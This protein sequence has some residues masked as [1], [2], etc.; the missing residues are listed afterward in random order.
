[1]VL[2]GLEDPQMSESGATFP[3]QVLSLEDNYRVQVK[4][5]QHLLGQIQQ[6][7]LPDSERQAAQKLATDLGLTLGGVG[8]TEASQLAWTIAQRLT[9]TTSFTA[10]TLND[11]NV[12]G[13]KLAELT[14]ADA[15]AS[16]IDPERPLE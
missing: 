8:F 15:N 12:W 3:Q 5:L 9:E 16:E 1:M 14:Q 11:L 6:E 4:Q 13:A 7:V 10:D 2:T